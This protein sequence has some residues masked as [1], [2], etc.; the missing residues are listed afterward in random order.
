MLDSASTSFSSSSESIERTQ[1]IKNPEDMVRETTTNFSKLKKYIDICCDSEGVRVTFEVKP[2]WNS[3]CALKDR[4]IRLRW[5]TEVTRDNIHYCK[6]LARIAELRHLDGLKSAF[7]IHDGL[8]Y[9]ASAK[10]NSLGQL[11]RELIITNVKEIVEQQQYVYDILWARAMPFRQRIREIEEGAKR[12]FID[13]IQDFDEIQI[14]LNTALKSVT[15][16]VM[17]IF[18]SVNIFYQYVHAGLLGKISDLVSSKQVTVRIL[19]PDTER[20]TEI[21]RMVSNHDILKKIGL[22]Y[23]SKNID[24]RLTIFILDNEF[25]LTI[26]VR[27]ESKNSLLESTG[28][29]TFSNSESTVLSYISIFE[30]LWMNNKKP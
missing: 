17:I 16:E 28:L 21:N 30:N 29:A 10:V 12:D 3:Y 15:N 18:P 8:E 7:G 1:V 9:R 13:T 14:V 20:T 4:G 11:P 2:I 23:Y 19:L 24:N 25:S 26:E 5:I 6:E 22:I 27:G